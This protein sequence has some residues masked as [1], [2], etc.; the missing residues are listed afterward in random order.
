MWL[1][2]LI[3]RLSITHR[4]A[5]PPRWKWRIHFTQLPGCVIVLPIDVIT[6]FAILNLPI[7]IRCFVVMFSSLRNNL[8]ILISLF[9]HWVFKW[10]CVNMLTTSFGLLYKIAPCWPALIESCGAWARHLQSRDSNDARNSG[11][12][13]KWRTIVGNDRKRVFKSV[14][15]A[16]T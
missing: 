9:K 7:Y 13:R 1:N 2:N 3:L 5:A 11:L 14:E 8:I 15:W 10:S 4:S 16:C 12:G 6:C